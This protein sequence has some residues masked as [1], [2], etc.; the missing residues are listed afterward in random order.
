M[1]QR[2]A[3][4]SLATHHTSVDH[5]T[6]AFFAVLESRGHEPLVKSASGKCA[7]LDIRDGE[8]VPRIG[9]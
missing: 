7:V 5:L 9:T 4:W 8:R 6:D 3:R 1:I 2:G